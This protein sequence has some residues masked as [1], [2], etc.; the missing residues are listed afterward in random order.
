MKKTKLDDK[1]TI[2]LQDYKRCLKKLDKKFD[3]IFIDPPYKK[4][5]GVDAIELILEQNLFAKDGI[6]I[7]ETD[8]E[9]RDIKELEKILLSPGMDEWIIELIL[10]MMP[11][12]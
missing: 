7:L 4:D 3:I 10:E 6:I 9:K 2:F 5:I 11:I 1:S 12:I 8:D